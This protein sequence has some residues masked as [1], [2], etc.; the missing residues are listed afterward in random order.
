MLPE[1][2]AAY[3]ELLKLRILEAKPESALKTYYARLQWMKLSESVD[4][5]CQALM[6]N[7]SL[8]RA[9]RNCVPNPS[10]PAAVSAAGVCEYLLRI[11]WANKNGGVMESLKE[12]YIMSLTER[13]QGGW[14]DHVL[15]KTF[16]LGILPLVPISGAQT[17]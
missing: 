17:K 15:V 2:K 4:F 7:S 3:S 16:G 9:Y 12:D 13:L 8:A 14:G 10:D 6:N 1:F 11:E 5:I